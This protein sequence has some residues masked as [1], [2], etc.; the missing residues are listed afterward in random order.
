MRILELRFKNLNSLQGEW[1]INFSD[2][3]YVNNGI[4]ALTGPTGAGK[5]TILDA[6]CL[7]L[8]GETP[9]LG[10][11]TKGEN[12]IMS[13][14]T[15]ECYAE[16]VF[17]SQ[18]GIYRCHW[19]QRKARKSPDGALQDQIHEIAEITDLSNFESSKLIESK[20]SRVVAVI[21]EK[22]GMDFK[23]FNRSML[24][25]QGSFDSFLKADVG[26]KSEIL[27]QITGTEIYSEISTQV[28]KRKSDEQ[29][30]L[31]I[32]QAEVRGI[33]L[34]TDDEI[35][36]ITENISTQKVTNQALKAALDQTR[37]AVDWLNNIEKLTTDLTNIQAEKVELT[38]LTI[39]FQ[40]KKQQLLMAN[41]AMQLDGEYA[42]LT[43][44]RDGLSQSQ[45]DL[46]KHNEQLPLAK[47]TL[48]DAQKT[49]DDT[50][51][52]HQAQ[53]EHHKA[54]SAIWQQVRTLDYAISEKNKV[55]EALVSQCTAI[56][57][58]MQEAQQK[59]TIQQGEY[60]Q[61]EIKLA[62]AQQYLTEHKADEWLVNH[63]FAVKNQLAQLQSQALAIE[64]QK[65]S[66][67]SDHGKLKA[68]DIQIEDKTAELTKI[69]Q[70]KAKIN[71][72][73]TL[74][75]KT[76][77]DLLA[78][79]SLPE[80]RREK[81][82][83]LR[84]QAL[85]N[86][87]VS[88]EE[89]RKRLKDDEACPLCGALDHPY[90]KGQ[91]PEQDIVEKKLEI[92]I[93]RID[94]LE[95]HEALCNQID[96]KIT[97]IDLQITLKSSELMQLQEK[98]TELVENQQKNSELLMALEKQYD[99]LNR[100]I[101]ASLQP[102]NIMKSMNHDE[103]LDH[104]NERLNQWQTEQKNAESVQTSLVVI[105]NEI[106]QLSNHLQYK[107]D[108]LAAKQ[109]E[110]TKIQKELDGKKSERL[111]LFGEHDVE[112][113]EAQL[114]AQLQSLETQENKAK[115]VQQQAQQALVLTEQSILQLTQLIT[116][117]QAK[118]QALD[119]AFVVSLNQYDFMNEA[120]FL[121][122]RLP[123]GIR[124]QLSNEAK[125]LEQKEMDLV[126]REKDRTAQLAIE[127]AKNI[128]TEPLEILSA[129]LIEQENHW[130]EK[131]EQLAQLEFKLS[132]NS[133]ALSRIAEKKDAIDAQRAECQRWDKL[134]G[135]I[136]SADGK[137]YRNFAQGLTFEL[138]VNNANRQLEKMTDRYLLMRDK[139]EPLKLNVI[140]HYQAGEERSTKNLSGGESFIIS[141]ALALGL[142]KMASQKVRVDSLFLDEGF[143]T[144]DEEALDTALAVLSNLHGE[145][146]LIGIISHVS[147]LKERI[148]TQIRIKPMSGGRSEIIGAGCERIA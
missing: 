135:L 60:Q 22:T 128:T 132:E 10:K 97:A 110:L 48:A 90:A 37:I 120:A 58:V 80:Y 102:L 19:E 96:K 86:R 44:V 91:M 69:E 9:R 15:G 76:Q 99:D 109:A 62:K 124:E 52:Q 2:P 144:L 24:L 6:I 130:I 118:L 39:E 94:Q 40:P 123:N 27:E 20:K 12:E 66:N 30:Q 117:M 34:L 71:A 140:D 42:K 50:I 77:Q 78:G 104:L 115:K 88:L 139:N 122:A 127:R 114:M 75:Q 46:V 83:L 143:G 63:F 85:L 57:S 31:E 72:E 125:Q 121:S 21:E 131:Q 93:Q 11:I 38:E 18:A 89:E 23:R 26:H 116:K 51:A 64:N 70:D 101:Y 148:Q 56:E 136:G 129:Q 126:A 35:A 133:K 142:S 32:L 47:N 36:E 65:K 92:L 119:A 147:A 103:L 141:L 106:Q 84:E 54:Q 45:K 53:K 43:A 146:K 98:S 138:M 111:E 13:R 108:D 8:Y 95:I 1:K 145:G 16:V 105:N 137:K 100:E 33:Q 49:L 73:L 25:A 74:A 61:N 68:I 55:A 59:L 112:T 5:S 4:F 41:R 29:K 14:H 134:H 113:V 28:H 7:A 3:E 82:S 17:Q 81:E 107:K 67:D 79:K 87:I